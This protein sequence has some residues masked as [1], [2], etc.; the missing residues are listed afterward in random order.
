MTPQRLDY[1]WFRPTFFYFILPV[2]NNT[3]L[4]LLSALTFQYGL[5]G[6]M[7]KYRIFSTLHFEIRTSLCFFYTVSGLAIPI[8]LGLCIH[9]SADFPN[10]RRE[11]NLTGL[12]WNQ[13]L[14]RLGCLLLSE[15]TIF[16]PVCSCHVASCEE[17]LFR[18]CR[19]C[20]QHVES[21]Q[22]KKTGR[23]K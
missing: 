2:C 3:N 19:R 6:Q 17:N 14:L 13:Q 11:F 9:T 23:V 15:Q 4:S 21:V 5:T 12:V 16:S 18:C 1:L 8:R 20:W 10:S 22:T 7:L